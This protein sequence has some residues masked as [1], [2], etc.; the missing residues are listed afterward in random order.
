M[1]DKYETTSNGFTMIDPEKIKTL[2]DVIAIL[3]ALEIGFG[4]TNG[5]RDRIEHLVKTTESEDATSNN[6]SWD[7]AKPF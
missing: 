5:Y 1:S 2:N 3:Q 6:T 4:P 7:K